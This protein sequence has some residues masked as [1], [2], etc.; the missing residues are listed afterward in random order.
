MSK[1][2]FHEFQANIKPHELLENEMTGLS[3]LYLESNY[4][5]ICNPKI[6]SNHNSVTFM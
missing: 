1:K 3:C 5:S 2:Q 6:T 4:E